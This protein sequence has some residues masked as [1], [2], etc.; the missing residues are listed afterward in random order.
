M[1]KIIIFTLM[2]ISSILAYANQNIQGYCTV[3]GQK[4]VTAGM[5]S[6]GYAMASYPECTVT[7]R[8]VSDN[9]LA[10][11][12]SD[13]LSTPTPLANPFTS[14]AQGYWLLYAAY[15]RYNITL[16]GGGLS[17][18]VTISDVILQ[19]ANSFIT[20]IF[21]SP[22]PIGNVA[23]NTGSFTEINASSVNTVL[24]A[25]FSGSTPGTLDGT[26][27]SNAAA[28]NTEVLLTR[29]GSQTTYT[30]AA[31]ITLSQSNLILHCEPG[32]SIATS[33]TN[34]VALTYTGTNLTIQGCILNEAGMTNA[35]TLFTGFNAGSITLRD[36]QIINS[37]AGN[38]GADFQNVSSVILDNVT[39][40]NATQIGGV[41]N[42]IRIM[43]GHFGE[44]N[45]QNGSGSAA[46]NNVIIKGAH[47]SV[48]P[49]T[50]TTNPMGL[51]VTNTSSVPITNLDVD[52]VIDITGTSSSAP[53]FGGISIVGNIKNC[54]I[55]GTINADGQYMTQGPVEL[56]VNGC[57][58]ALNISSSDP[59]VAPAGQTYNG[60]MSYYGHNNFAGTSVIGWGNNGTGLLIYPGSTAGTTDGGGNDI[61]QVILKNA[62]QL[63]G[64][65]K[66]L[67]IQCNVSGYSSL[68]NQV[69]T[70]IFEGPFSYGP[71]IEDDTGGS[72]PASASLDNNTFIGSGTGVRAY[73]TGSGTSVSVGP[74]RYVGVTTT[75]P[76]IIGTAVLETKVMG[77][78]LSVPSLTANTVSA[79]TTVSATSPIIDPRAATY[80][81]KC[82]GVTDD[83]AALQ[84]AINAADL[85]SG[86][87]RVFIP[88][89]CEISAPLVIAT[90]SG[91]MQIVGDGPNV[92]K[93]EQK[94]SNT[95]VIQITAGNLHHFLLEGMALGWSAQQPA[96]NTSAVGVAVTGNMYLSK[97]NNL[98][99][100][101]GFRG[102]Q[103]SG[104]GS[105]WGSE[106]T[107][108]TGSG[109]SNTLSGSTLNLNSSLTGMVRNSFSHILS[110]QTVAEPQVFV[111]YCYGC[112]LSNI[113]SLNGLNNI[114]YLGAFDGSLR[115][116]NIESLTLNTAQSAA[117]LLA[118]ANVSV[119][120]LWMQNNSTINAGA[121]N[122]VYII[123]QSGANSRI[124]LDRVHVRPLTIT[125]GSAYL[126]HTDFQPAAGN[127]LWDIGPQ[128]V[129]DN[130]SMWQPGDAALSYGTVQNSGTTRYSNPIGQAVATS[131][132]NVNSDPQYDQGSY[133]SGTGGALD[134]WT[135]QVVEGTGANPS[136]T[137]T[138]T[139]S[140]SSGVAALS[141]PVLQ[142]SN[143]I[144]APYGS[145]TAPAFTFSSES[146]TG[147]WH[148][149]AG[150]LEFSS[151]GN[152]GP[153]FTGSD[154]RLPSGYMFS[155]SP[156]SDP[157]GG[158]DTA[159]MR[160]VVGV[161]CVWDAAGNC[162]GSFKTETILT[163]GNCAVNSASPAACGSAAVGAFVAP[164]TTTT[165]TVNTTVVTAASRIFLFP[166]SFA[167]NLPGSPTCVAPAVTSTATISAVSAGTSF[168]LSLPSTT[169]QT[170]WSYEIVN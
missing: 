165:Y 141:A 127:S 118:T 51:Q 91:G 164:T 99:F 109:G 2:L 119:D 69:S 138:F 8:N 146:G 156:T 92:S 106:F 161:V 166:M 90:T 1:R 21:S 33:L 78:P 133:W 94:T 117:I 32:V 23:P 120:G 71:T 149:Y 145:V 76:Q 34:V 13:N 131:G 72:C 52:V 27:I 100:Y 143:S 150:T 97:F 168:T 93:I 20:G 25:A 70:S 116:V 18:P 43:G 36:T 49:S 56:G 96:T 115:D 152:K 85:L 7:V 112:S 62:T 124:K 54:S 42:D 144:Q 24:N 89:Q 86:G 79:D 102:I 163:S 12:Y 111:Q 158:E 80:G 157:L 110:Q 155:W 132:A 140:G 48:T 4:I 160:S 151:G 66:P 73:S 15:G 29:L 159:L 169:G 77:S 38:F 104:S 63:A 6:T 128:V 147:F 153:M 67:S 148:P 57:N 59:S 30:I 130:I 114:L 26:S 95:P 108:I 84:A 10:T 121:G 44:I 60:I 50:A 139:H 105:I 9:S 17:S 41:S 55:A 113:E 58:V 137:L 134:V 98:I 14:T 135:R 101:S 83:T 154:L 64:T 3:G 126:A 129:L 45:I 31:P 136:S 123:G 46:L 16:S 122:N 53:V 142:A 82:D 170:C 68:N 11:I 39:N 75:A 125:S 47:I 87:S 65:G 22:P 103:V 162:N 40:L 5:S 61:S 37:P 74:N 28:A 35:S 81:A 19:D 107:Q 88:G 167:S